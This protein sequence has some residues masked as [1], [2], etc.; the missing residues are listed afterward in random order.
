M[1]TTEIIL[2]ILV[3][4]GVLCMGTTS[5]FLLCKSI[6]QPAEH[7]PGSFRDRRL[8]VITGYCIQCVFPNKSGSNS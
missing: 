4:A 8:F 6:Y 7:A 2:L 3:G 1:T 5:Q